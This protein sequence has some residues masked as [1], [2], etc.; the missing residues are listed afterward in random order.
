MIVLVVW[1]SCRVY[2]ERFGPSTHLVRLLMMIVSVNYKWW[3]CALFTALLV[4]MMINDHNVKRSPNTFVS[5]HI[6]RMEPSQENAKWPKR[7]TS[8]LRLCSS[9]WHR[10]VWVID[11]LLS[12]YLLNSNILLWKTHCFC[13]VIKTKCQKKKKIHLICLLSQFSF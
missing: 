11:Y 3:S 1:K 7:M 5:P 2:F 4:L 6:I 10:K 13:V 12:C 8:V 9:V